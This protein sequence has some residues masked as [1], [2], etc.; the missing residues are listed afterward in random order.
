MLGWQGRWFERT[1]Q[2]LNATQVINS[3]PAAKAREQTWGNDDT[4]IVVDTATSRTI[5]P[6][7][8]DLIDPQQYHCPLE[9]IGAGKIT[10][11]GKIRW[12]IVDDNGKEVLSRR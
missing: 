8:S 4:P 2:I 3:F 9:G 12:K 6:K 5:T 1:R 10:H 7:L 11:R